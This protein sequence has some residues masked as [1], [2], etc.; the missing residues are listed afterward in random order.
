MLAL[1]AE[2]LCWLGLFVIAPITGIYYPVS[3][4]PHW[5]QTLSWMLPSTYVFEGMR[6]VLFDHT[7]RWDLLI[8]AT[9]IN[10]LY[11]AFG[12][13][14]FLYMFGVARRRGLLLQQGE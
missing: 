4:L 9:A 5:L 10:V 8:G 3:V 1:G 7:F 13:G 2:S 11:L 12:A 6:A 14:F